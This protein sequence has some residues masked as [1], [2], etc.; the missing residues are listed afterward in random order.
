MHNNPFDENP[1]TGQNNGPRFGNAYEDDSNNAWS[2]SGPDPAMTGRM[3]SPSDYRPPISHHNNSAWS[4][5][6]KTEYPAGHD[7]PQNAWS[8]PDDRSNTATPTNAYQYA[9][10][11]FGNQDSDPGNAY[12]K[13]QVDG[14]TAAAPSPTA[15]GNNK[16]KPNAAEVEGALPPVWDK[17][18]MNP[19]KLRLA[20]RFLQL[21]ASVGHLGFA[22]GASPVIKDLIPDFIVYQE[23]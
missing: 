23:N 11:R 3:P 15:A 5:S 16:P 1:W 20:F 7:E 8:Q 6:N 9:G 19:S 17:S 13:V 21:I 12:S 10:T 22:A 4:E 18:R 14:N 2:N